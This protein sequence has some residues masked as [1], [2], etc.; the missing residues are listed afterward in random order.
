MSANRAMRAANTQRLPSRFESIQVGLRSVPLSNRRTRPASVIVVTLL[1]GFIVVPL[2]SLQLNIATEQGV[3]ELAGLK[4]Q[5]KDLAITSQILGQQLDSLSSDQNLSSAATQL[6]M[7]SN[8]NPVF[9]RIA[10]QRIFGHPKAATA[11]DATHLGSNLVPN[12]AQN[13]HTRVANLLAQEAAVKTQ[14]IA[15]RKIAALKLS[16]E[17]QLPQKSAG[18]LA[19]AKRPAPVAVKVADGIPASPTN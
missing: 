10:D 4:A 15:T 6:G 5:K 7:V 1:I 9:L 12:A 11:A 16:T 8:T 18:N 14:I 3:Y 2:L 17:T 13:K 19:S